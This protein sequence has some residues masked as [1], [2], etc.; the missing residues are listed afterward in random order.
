MVSAKASNAKPVVTASQ[1]PQKKQKTGPAPNTKN[2]FEAFK[3]DS[4][5]D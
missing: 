4:D 1:P 3:S 2:P 5:S